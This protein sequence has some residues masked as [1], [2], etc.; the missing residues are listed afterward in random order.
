MHHPANVSTQDERDGD[1]QEDTLDGSAVS[2]EPVES[3]Q[4]LGTEPR[5]FLL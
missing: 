5:T 1:E 3:K 4:T 2:G